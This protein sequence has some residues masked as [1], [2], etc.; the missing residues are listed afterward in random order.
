LNDS[1]KHTD[2]QIDER[3]FLSKNIS[4]E[5]ISVSQAMQELDR[6]IAQAYLPIHQRDP[7]MVQQACERMDRMRE[8]LRARIG[9]VDLAVE[10]IREARDDEAGDDEARS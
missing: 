6:A 10:L 8:E 4:M 1:R 7:V 9:T 5:E 3:R 2:F